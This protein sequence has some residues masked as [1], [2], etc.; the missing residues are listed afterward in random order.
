MTHANPAR[1]TALVFCLITTASLIMGCLTDG[2]VVTDGTGP[3]ANAGNNRTAAPGEVVTLDGTDSSDP[4]GRTLTYRWTRLSF[5]PIGGVTVTLD[6]DSSATPSFVAPQATTTTTLQF[7][8][9]VIAGGSSDT[10]TVTVTIN[11]DRAPGTPTADAGED[12]QARPG[13]SVTLDGTDSSDPDGDDLTYAW[14]LVDTG[15]V[16]IQNADSAT[17]TLIAPSVTETTTIEIR[18]TVSDGELTDTDTVTITVATDDDPRISV[19]AV[20]TYLL[21]DSLTAVESATPTLSAVDRFGR[22]EFEFA[23]VLGTS[24]K[25]YRFEGDAIPPENQG[26]LTL[27]TAGLLSGDSYSIEMVVA[28]DDSGVWRRLLD[29]YDR[30]S[31]IGLYVSDR[32]RVQ[33]W[34]GSSGASSWTSGFHHLIVTFDAD[35]STVSVYLDGDAEFATTS[36]TMK[37]SNSADNTLTF[38]VDNTTAGTTTEW[39]SGQVALVRLWDG[40]LSADEVELLATDPFATGSGT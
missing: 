34:G 6:D 24:Q 14:T 23:N 37:L 8:L 18:L 25:V 40:V 17:A 30:A 4:L 28:F 32:N 36:T 29:T 1:I 12:Q 5:T 35:P 26:G 3:T 33:L 2:E 7:S 9:T 13:D 22:N 20:A 38:F 31:D 11:P 15:D 39:S 16:T 10:D 27:S 19:D 21:Q